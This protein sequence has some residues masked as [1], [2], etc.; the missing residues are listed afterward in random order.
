MNFS[1]KLCIGLPLLV[2]LSL[3]AACSEKEHAPNGTAS[4]DI[5]RSWPE[6]F[7]EHKAYFQPRVYQIEDKPIWSVNNAEEWAANSIVIEGE[8]GLIVYDTG[9]SQ[10]HGEAIMREVRKFSDKPVV[11]IFYSH[12]HPDHYNGTTAFVSEEDVKAGKV[13]IY[14]WHNFVEEMN[15]EFGATAPAQVVRAAYYSGLALPREERHFHGCCGSRYD[16]VSGYIAPTNT[17]S[18]N[19]RLTIE[20]VE[21]EVFYTGGEAKSEFGIYLPQYKTIMVADEIFH[22]VPN[23]YTIRGAKFR[24]PAGY[25]R[26][27]DAV[28]N[29][30]VEHLLGSHLV[31]LHG[32]DNIIST[33]TKYRD[34]VQWIND[35]SIRYINKGYGIEELKAQ[36]SEVPAYLENGSFSKEMYGT[37]EH[38]APQIFAGLMGHFSGDATEYRPTEPVEL[39]R[40]HIEL[41]GGRDRVLDAARDAFDN[42]DPQFAAE[43]LTYLIRVDHDDMDARLLKAAA[44][45]KLGYAE[46]NTTWR[47]WYLTSAMELEGSLTPAGVV[48]LLKGIVYAKLDT[49]PAIDII[50]GMR[51]RVKAEEVGEQEITVSYHISDSNERFTASLRHGV[52][53]VT[54]GLAEQ[55]DARLVMTRETFNRIAKNELVTGEAIAAGTVELAGDAESLN[56]FLRSFDENPFMDRLAIR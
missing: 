20:G 6:Y 54:E 11:A 52:L 2:I 12:H 33:V 22:S 9:L 38:I 31:P 34:L 4:Y 55:A 42:D 51:Y 17:F 5:E 56:V 43:L 48:G 13:K 3:L 45:R 15:S 32:R 28:L 7:E 35:Q 47:S 49:Q 16:G 37:L 21:L 23:I 50:E 27:V 44:F 10:Q 41:M 26:A 53:V 24:E 40:R 39:A 29:Y 18:G 36:F 1:V 8:Q 25:I 30:D 19:K 46:L 14:A